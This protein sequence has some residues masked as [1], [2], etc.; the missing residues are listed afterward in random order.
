MT[1][2][3]HFAIFAS[4]FFFS[5]GHAETAPKWRLHIVTNGFLH[6]KDDELFATRKKCDGVG[7]DLAA[8]GKIRSYACRN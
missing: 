7:Y 4:L 2:T 3:L 8:R 1:R 6:Q 5:V